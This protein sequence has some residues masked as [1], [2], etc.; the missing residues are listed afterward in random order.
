MAVNNEKNHRSN[1]SGRV[2]MSPNC[3]SI[4]ALNDLTNRNMKAHFG[5][6]RFWALL[7][8]QKCRATTAIESGQRWNSSVRGF[9]TGPQSGM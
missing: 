3:Q 7:A 8:P 5:D 4:N 9:M 2:L 1:T 6:K